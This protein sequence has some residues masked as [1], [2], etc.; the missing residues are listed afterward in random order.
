MLH[1]G[2][3]RSGG[4]GGGTGAVRTKGAA[5]PVALQSATRIGLARRMT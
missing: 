4:G 2:E 1:K 3:W 5:G